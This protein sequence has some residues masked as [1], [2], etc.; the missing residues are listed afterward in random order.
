MIDAGDLTEKP[1]WVRLSVHPTMTDGEL[2][3]IL[4]AIKQV[5]VNIKDWEKDYKFDKGVGEFFHKGI[6]RLNPEEFNEWFDY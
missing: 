4:D 5:I 2:N 1:G 3:F 6:P